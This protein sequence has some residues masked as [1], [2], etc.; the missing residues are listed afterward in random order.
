MFNKIKKILYSSAKAVALK[1]AVPAAA[2]RIWKRIRKEKNPNTLVF[3]SAFAMGDMLYC[4]APLKQIKRANP[5]KKIVV[6]AQERFRDL[7]ESFDSY[8][9]AEFIPN[10]GRGGKLLPLVSN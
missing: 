2:R 5:D 3:I 7:I 10:S 1:F 6:V 9:H 4:M 8:D